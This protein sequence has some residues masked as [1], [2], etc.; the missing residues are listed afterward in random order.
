MEGVGETW[1]SLATILEPFTRVIKWE[2]LEDIEENIKLLPAIRFEAP[3]SIIQGLSLL[4][5]WDI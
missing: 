5:D 4:P 1:N 2:N 3:K